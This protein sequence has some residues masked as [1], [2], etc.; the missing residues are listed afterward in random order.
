MSEQLIF[1]AQQPENA[2]EAQ[3]QFN[4]RVE[5]SDYSADTIDQPPEDFATSLAFDGDLVVTSNSATVTAAKAD[6]DTIAAGDGGG[7]EPGDG[8]STFMLTTGQDNLTG[9]DEDDAFNAYIF[10]NQNT[11]Q[12]GDVLDGGA[13]TDSLYADIG[14]SQ[15]FAITL[16]TSNVENFAV[17]AQAAAGDSN[18]NNLHSVQIDA[19]RMNGVTRYESNNS[20]DD[21]IIEDVRIT[22]SEITKDITIAMV[23]TDPGAVDFGVYFDQHSLR[24][25]PAVTAGAV[26][27]LEIMDTRSA[28]AGLDPLLQSPFDGFTF[29]LDGTAFVVSS[30]AIDDATTYTDYLAAVQ[31]E[32]LNVAGL[33]GFTAAISGTFQAIDT[34]SGNALTGQTITLTNAG[35]GIIEEG[36]WTTADGTVPG[37]SGLHL[38]QDTAPPAATGNLITSTIILDDVGRGSMGGDLII[39]GL[40]TGATS[41]SKGVE[42]FDIT[43]ERTSELQ[44]INSTN[45]TL[46]E[47]YLVNGATKGNLVIAGDTN[48]DND[49]PG[50]QGNEGVNDVRIFDASAMQ[51]SV[52]VDARLS[53][54]VVGKYMT[55]VDDATNATA[56][57]IDFVYT[58]G[59]GGDSFAIKLSD[60]N[61]AAAGTTTREDFTLL[62]NGGAGNDTILTS[63]RAGDGIG[64]LSATTGPTAW[65]TNSTTNAN[66]MVDGGSGNDTITTS[67]GGNFKIDAGSGNDTVYTDNSG[68]GGTNATWVVNATNIVL[69][70]LIGDTV[71]L[72]A[73][74][75]QLLY[76]STLTVTYSGAN[77]A[78]VG[79]VTSGAAAAATNGFESTVTIG[80]TDYV[81]NKT[82]INQ[83]IKDAI[84]NDAVL[85]KLLMA[86]DGPANTLIITSK[87]DGTFVATDIKVDITQADITTLS[88]SELEGLDTAWEIL[89]ANSA[90]AAVAQGNLTAAAAAAAALYVDTASVDFTATVGTASVLQSDNIVNLGAGDD[91]VVLGTSVGAA[92]ESNDTLVFAGTIGNNTVV[93][94]E[95]AATGFQD[96][97]DFTGYLGG[98]TSATGSA[99]SQVLI[100][101]TGDAAG[102][103]ATTLTA[104]EV[105][106]VNNWVQDIAG[107]ATE[108]WANM[109]AA[110]VLAAIQA[111]NIAG[112]ADYGTL[113]EVSF[114][115]AAVATLVGNV[116]KGIIMIENDL[117][118]GEYKVFETT[119]DDTTTEFT[120]V[121]LVGTIDFGNSVDTTVAGVLV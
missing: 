81:G 119:A 48:G 7:A 44:E 86:V 56:D 17:R 38:E 34:L 118:Q 10:D 94:F 53:G 101:T 96:K 71:S 2:G 112:G 68:G 15:D 30:D 3:D 19:E 92:D 54:A 31:A 27:N 21:V 35:S 18:E 8:G 9:T 103:A 43:V 49:L 73:A 24:A 33:E 55:L 50:A 20:R 95:N 78:V 5:V 25:A 121:T 47:M 70:N 67:G 110:N 63:I 66:L 60:Q 102:V 28:D 93:N 85:N 58:G 75:N 100:A 83:A 107:G 117:N 57:N 88:A 114:D 39:G 14:N 11:A 90:I 51:G 13:G 12:S 62:V 23:Q 61:L 79:G 26:L 111:T 91:V 97:L 87:I 16:H 99:E 72:G 36:A 116:Q 42:R 40:S 109:T 115:V 98:M 108:T 120:A 32:L 4:N 69:G 106:V 64:A 77:G 6:I 29:K 59:A 80:T 45:N 22:N 84:N 104:N 82:N 105:A 1:A 76:K 41:D 65:Y 113:V 37:G 46:Q 74:T 52:S 89:N